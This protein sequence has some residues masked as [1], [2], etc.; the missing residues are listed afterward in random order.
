[1][2][3]ALWLQESR[4]LCS[5]WDLG[6]SVAGLSQDLSAPDLTLNCSVGWA[7]LARHTLCITRQ[8]PVFTL[9]K[10]LSPTA[11]SERDISIN[12]CCI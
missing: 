4:W 9:F 7:E 11:L 8:G 5:P 2:G 3:V 1:M 12:G 6:C 10:I